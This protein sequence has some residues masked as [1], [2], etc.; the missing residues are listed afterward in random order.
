MKNQNT[1]RKVKGI[2][3]ILKETR[4]DPKAMEEARRLS[5]SG[6]SDKTNT[7]LKS[8]DSLSEKSSLS[9]T[10]KTENPDIIDEF[11]QY[12]DVNHYQVVDGIELYDFL[13]RFG[14][15]KEEQIAEEIKNWVKEHE[16]DLPQGGFLVYADDLEAFIDKRY[17]GGLR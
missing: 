15:L 17:L 14:K 1:K 12:H 5:K 9:R 10:N 13:K 6:N 4:E 3:Q 11:C 2:K 8:C 16:F 7:G